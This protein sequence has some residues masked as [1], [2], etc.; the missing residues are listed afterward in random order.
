MCTEAIY[1]S[2]KFRAELIGKIKVYRGGGS[3]LCMRKIHQPLSGGG[4]F[5]TKGQTESLI[6]N[7][8]HQLVAALAFRIN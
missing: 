4:E 5:S 2:Q 6:T 3:G 7:L 1:L 8:T